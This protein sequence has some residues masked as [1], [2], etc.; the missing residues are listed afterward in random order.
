MENRSMRRILQIS[1]FAGLLAGAGIGACTPSETEVADGPVPAGES[2][3]AMSLAA[4]TPSPRMP[5]AGRTSP[6]D[7][8][9]VPLGATALKVC[10]GRPS[11]RGRTVFGGLVPFDTLW[12]TGANEPT[13]LHTPVA[14]QVAG[15]ALDAVSYSLYTVPGQAG[16]TVVVNRSTSQWGHESQY[17]AAV[18]AQEVGRA[19][20]QARVVSASAEQFTIRG[21]AAGANAATLLLEWGTTQVRVPVARR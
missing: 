8:T 1:L 13:V 10:Y 4:C 5:V 20:V 17:N 6:Y 15:L 19:P 12:R 3:A 14:V 2:R 21:E 16:W 11:A 18:R 7:S 9:L